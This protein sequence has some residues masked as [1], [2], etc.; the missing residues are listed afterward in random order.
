V[1]PWS[2]SMMAWFCMCLQVHKCVD[3]HV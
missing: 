3:A 2:L 1:R